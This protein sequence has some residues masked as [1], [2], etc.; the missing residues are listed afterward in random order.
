MPVREQNRRGAGGED[1]MGV[2]DMGLNQVALR[3][4]QTAVYPS[5]TFLVIAQLQKLPKTS[6]S[7]MTKSAKNL[8]QADRQSHVCL[9]QSILFHKVLSTAQPPLW[10]PQEP[11]ALEQRGSLNL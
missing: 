9:Q 5:P 6:I 2:V 11:L 3:P 10:K 4:V 1:G 7:Q 8:V